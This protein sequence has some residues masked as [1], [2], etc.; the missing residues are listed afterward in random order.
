VARARR[1]D[2]LAFELLVRRHYA[3]TFSVAFAV[4]GN[5]LDAE[6]ICHDGFVRALARLDD[7]RQ[8]ERFAQWVGAIVRNHARNELTRPANRRAMELDERMEAKGEGTA[9][10]AEM[11]D[12]RATLERAL[13]QLP[14]VERE[15]VLLSDLHDW[16][17]DKIAESIGT[18]PAMSRQYLFKARRR[19]RE[20]LGATLLK[21]H[22]DG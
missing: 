20:L 8:P 22:F 13:G 15:V 3:A 10:R 1:G 7:C 17:H 19:L 18:S 4:M 16:P 9:R 14:E 5:R 21:E 11:D 2:A 12:L 6:D